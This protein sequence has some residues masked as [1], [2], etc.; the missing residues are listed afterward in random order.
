MD[1]AEHIA[2]LALEGER[3][4][5]AGEEAGPDALVPTC[6]EWAVR[7]LLHHQGGL[8]RWSAGYVAGAVVER[9]GLDY[10]TTVGALPDDAHLIEWF[11]QCHADLVETLRSADPAVQCWTFMAAPSPLAFWARRQAHE[12]SIHRVDA[13]LAA[14]LTPEVVTPSFGADGLDELLA[15]FFARRQ[16][17]PRADPPRSLSVRCTDVDAGWRMTV[18]TESVTTTAEADAGATAP[19]CIVRGP[20]SDLYHSLWNRLPADV[21]TIEGDS[22]ALDLFMDQYKVRWSI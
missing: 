14:E 4:A 9:K 19:D 1:I 15:G 13:E 21:L 16:G 17:D 18:S 11:G 2:V 5:S 7:D 20:A 12:S 8:F 6:P 22:A 10:D 3:I